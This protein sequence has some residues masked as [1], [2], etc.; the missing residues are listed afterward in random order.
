MNRY[1]PIV[2]ILGIVTT[3]T[4]PSP[5]WALERAEIA[6]K[7]K[8]FTVSIEGIETSGTGTIIQ[9]EASLYTVLTCWHVVEAEGGFEVTTVDGEVHQVTVVKNLEDIDLAILQFVSNTAYEVAE[10]G[11]SAAITEG[12]TNYVAGYP[13]PIPGIPEREYTFQNADIVSVLAT[14]EDGY[15]IVHGNPM[16]G[17]SSGGGIFDNDARL[18]G[19]N[20]RTTSDS[21]GITYRGLAI[22]S[23]LYFAAQGNFTIPA[24]I[25]PPQDFDVVL[26]SNSNDAKLF[27]Q[28]AVTHREIG[29]HKQAIADYNE[30]IRLNPEYADA[31]NN[32]GISYRRLG[33]DEQAIAD[34]NEAI[35]LSPEDAA[36]YNNRGI[37]YRN[38]G[39]YEQAIADHNEAIRLNPES[40]YAYNNR[41]HTYRRLGEDEIGRA[42]V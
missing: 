18:V 5:L 16:V 15:R 31:Y 12:A 11:D 19:I 34:Y 26:Q 2:P 41:G 36:A 25:S 40:K 28:R 22:P 8:E 27:F 10:L 21:G 4:L 13:D 35:R 17:G 30:A 38:L 37:S 24:N 7:V 32:R 29:E 39:E 42:H 14:G 6:A 20:G 1:L 3:I 23:E 9:Q 33:E